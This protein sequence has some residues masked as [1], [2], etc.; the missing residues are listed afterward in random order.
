MAEPILQPGPK[1]SPP[2]GLRVV[3]V[4]PWG[5]QCLLLYLIWLSGSSFCSKAFSICDSLVSSPTTSHFL[6]WGCSAPA[7]TARATKTTRTAEVRQGDDILDTHNRE[8]R[9]LTISAPCQLTAGSQSQRLGH[10]LSPDCEKEKAK[11]RNFSQLP[12][13]TKSESLA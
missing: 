13:E 12:T 10:F 11:S 7:P 9:G 1:F 4:Q 8:H 5:L 2:V 6:S 3:T